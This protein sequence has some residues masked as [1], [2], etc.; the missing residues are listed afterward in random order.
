MRLIEIV[1]I[2]EGAARRQFPVKSVLQNDIFEINSVP[3]LKY[4]VFAWTQQMHTGNIDADTTDFNFSLFYVDRLRVDKANELEVQSE[5]VDVL[6][7]VLKILA[8]VPEIEVSSYTIQTFRQ[9]FTDECAGAWVSLSI[10]TFDETS[11]P[12]S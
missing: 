10:Q 11:C 8:Q 2:I 3:N 4:G 12:E 1:D 6:R 5:A 9:R 7:N